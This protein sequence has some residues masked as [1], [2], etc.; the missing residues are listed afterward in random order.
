MS[1]VFIDRTYQLAVIVRC[2]QSARIVDSISKSDNHHEETAV[3]KSSLELI[4]T[5]LDKVEFV[6]REV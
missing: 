3:I 6:N 1:S 2:R 4:Q 5:H